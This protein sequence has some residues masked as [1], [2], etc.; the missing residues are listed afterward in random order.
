M[1]LA[2]SAFN[3]PEHLSPKST[4]SLIAGDEQHFAAIA[5]SLEQTITD[6]SV[7]LEAIKKSSSR[8]GQEAVEKDIETRD[9]KSVV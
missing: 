8:F 9:R 5:A 3:L 2:T 4:P 7:Q 1:P 6:L